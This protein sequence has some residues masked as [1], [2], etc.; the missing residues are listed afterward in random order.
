MKRLLYLSYYYEPDLSAGSF[1]NTSL[2]IE[3]AKQ[4]NTIAV[5]D[6]ITT[7]PNRYI[8]FDE[9]AEQKETKGNLNITRIKVTG[10]RG[11]MP[12][13]VLTYLSYYFAVL[14]AIRGTKYDL[15]FAS[16]SKLLTGYLGSYI[17]KKR[18]IP[19]YLDLR[20]IFFESFRDVLRQNPL[21]HI[22]LPL[23]RLVERVTLKRAVHVN[24]ISE[25]FKPYIQQFNLREVSYFTNGIDD[26]F[27]N[28]DM[29][30]K[31]PQEKKIV[32]YAGNIGEGQGLHKFIPQLAK[33]LG[34]LYE[35]RIVGDGGAKGILIKT[36]KSLDT[37][38]VILL[39]PISR[40]NLLQQYAE[41]DFNLIH[42]ND[43]EA[44][45]RVLPSKL[46]ELAALNKPIIAGV[47][48]YA[49]H[50]MKDNIENIILVE[51]GDVSDCIR[52]LKEYKYKY[53]NR[54]IF[55]NQFYRNR[56]DAQM[57]ASIARHL[58]QDE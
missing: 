55:K 22:L 57:S 10:Y 14:R 13:Q 6:V 35:F 31:S 8:S 21:K 30:E 58:L 50:F 36:I 4:L 45:K 27:M 16:S 1:R 44:F 3:L 24:L 9:E 37:P 23:I 54:K 43:C 20:D 42:L 52:Q 34:P 5:I 12:G 17:A 53:S 11:G 40:H 25:G 39:P 26:E 15:V 19:F 28:L 48:G 51:P 29:P 41:A 18:D 46:F 32:L 38:N 56:I 33:E 49:H 2:S 47:A 7:L